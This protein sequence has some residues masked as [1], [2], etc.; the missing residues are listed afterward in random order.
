MGRTIST[1]SNLL[2]CFDPPTFDNIYASTPLALAALWHACSRSKSQTEHLPQVFDSRLKDDCMCTDFYIHRVL[3]FSVRYWDRFHFLI[4]QIKAELFQQGTALTRL[5]P[6]P[7]IVA[8]M[9]F[10]SRKQCIVWG[11]HPSCTKKFSLRSNPRPKSPNIHPTQG[12]IW[13]P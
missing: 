10:L 7:I 11:S 6:K 5:S 1:K 9:T 2:H 12:F 3:L 4:R 8:A 13:G